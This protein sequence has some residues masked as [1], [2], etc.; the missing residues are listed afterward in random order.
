MMNQMIKN[1]ILKLFEQN[2][3][4]DGRNFTDFRG[5]ITIETGVTKTA[6]GS[7]IVTVG[8]CKVLAG[9][10]MSVEKPYP[11]SPDTGNLM[12]NAELL[13][14]SNPR[15]ERGPPTIEAI[16]VSR[17]IDRG[18]RESHAFDFKKLCIE[19][20]EKV[21]TVMVDITPLNATGN[22]FD[23]G[24]LAA[25]AALLDTKF[26]KFEDGVVNYKEHTDEKLPLTG[27]PVCVTIHKIGDKFLVDPVENE[28]LVSDARLTAWS[29]EDGTLVA[30]QKGGD[31]PLAIDEIDAMLTLSIEKAAELREH[32]VKLK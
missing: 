6:E 30:M 5:P 24:A 16:E 2:T 11:D 32:L 29:V 23:V 26:P 22:L 25:M 20:G 18:I 3:R 12:V 28:E 10:K 19:S 9:V 31:E 21:W 14:L 27:L 8:D 4:L 1:K 17:V 15:F 7:A 13:P